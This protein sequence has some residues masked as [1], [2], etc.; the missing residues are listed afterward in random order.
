MF[1]CANLLP[2]SRSRSLDPDVTLKDLHTS[3]IN[4]YSFSPRNYPKS[5]IMAKS[6][7][8]DSFWK[9]VKSNQNTVLPKLRDELRRTDNPSVFYWDGSRLLLSLS[10]DRGDKQLAVSAI[11]RADLWDV[12]TS[13]FI[14]MMNKFAREGIDTTDAA[15]R[16]LDY[17]GFKV[18]LPAHGGRI[19]DS[20]GS[21]IFM[22][23]P[24][25]EDVFIS[26]AIVRLEKEKDVAARKSLLGLLWNTVNR[27][28]DEILEKAAKD[29]RE[30]QEVS[31]FA[32]ELINTGN[33][34]TNMSRSNL[35][36][37]LK[38]IV[39]RDNFRVVRKELLASAKQ[40]KI[41]RHD[42]EEMLPLL[43]KWQHEPEDK[44]VLEAVND[45]KR[46]KTVREFAN[47][48]V[49][50]DVRISPIV[51][52][53]TLMVDSILELKKKRSNVL[54]EVSDEAIEEFGLYTSLIRWRQANRQ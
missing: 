28:G 41:S 16:V 33:Q 40:G 34:T 7:E 6:D 47:N 45:T 9:I 12:D 4:I 52:E 51:P 21:L 53:T 37:L 19:L 14:E 38:H 43:F 23:F 17:P 29:E 27:Q 36:S 11:A 31:A 24:L 49:I 2:Q 1:S 35:E 26:K 25:S 44:T 22:L 18:S 20:D 3:V 15:F 30:P 42:F 39:F 54:N 5:Q 13:V 48:L 46:S 8:L 32:K 10:N 50:N